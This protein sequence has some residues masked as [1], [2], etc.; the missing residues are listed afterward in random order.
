[1]TALASGTK[2]GRMALAGKRVLV[3][4]AARGLGL[5]LAT[6]L[7]ARGA[8]LSLVGLEPDLLQ[9]AADAL[10]PGHVWFAADVTDQTALDDAVQGTVAALGG[11]DAVVPNAG[12]ANMGTLA[13]GPVNA[14]VRTIDVN[15]NGTIRTVSACLPHLIESRGYALLIASVGSFSMFPGLGTYCAS[16]AA[17]EHLANAL[18]LELAHTGVRV[19][20][21]HPAFLNTDLVRDSD[22]TSR[23]F[24]AA[25]RRLRGP[26]NSTYSPRQC[27]E[28]LADGIAKRKRRVYVPR[29]LAVMQALR[30][31]VL[32][33]LG[34]AVLKRQLRTPEYIP[35]LED[36][37]TALGRAFG[38]KSV[39]NK[40][41]RAL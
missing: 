25:R 18:R 41:E 1:M 5:E 27:A 24:S 36:E 8:R 28:A 21:A 11:I 16:K 4:G 9:A 13:G 32:S 34:D 37:V 10:G 30:P 23:A 40:E 17:V 29:S 12:I 26:L 39:E 31:L 33:P 22:A 20:S 6:V 38:A 2:T 15:V 14:H 3:T 7:A 19:G 35:A